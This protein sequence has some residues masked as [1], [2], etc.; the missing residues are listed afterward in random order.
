MVEGQMYCEAD[1]R[2]ASQPGAG[3]GMQAVP[4]YRSKQIKSK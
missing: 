2:T 4:I 3:Q 1:A